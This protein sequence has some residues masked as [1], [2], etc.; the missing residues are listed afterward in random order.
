MRLG[1]KVAAAR[2]AT[3]PVLALLLQESDPRIIEAALLNPRLKEEDLLR[4]IRSDSVPVPLL[5]AVSEAPRWRDHY[6][7][8]LGLVLQP[9][10]PLGIALSC[11]SGLVRRD[12][13]RVSEAPGLRPVVQAAAL[14]VATGE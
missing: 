13:L 12:L 2:L 3:P 7:V 5:E 1:D 10:T 6:E 9:R 14:R 4:Q 8:R 11:V